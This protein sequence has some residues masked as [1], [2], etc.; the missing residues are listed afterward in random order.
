MPR[1][2]A[3]SNKLFP[4]Q[5]ARKRA[6]RKNFRNGEASVTRCSAFAFARSHKASVTR[7]SAS[8]LRGR[9]R[10]HPHELPLAI[11]FI[12]LRTGTDWLQRPHRRPPKNERLSAQ[13]TRRMPHHRSESF[14]LLRYNERKRRYPCT[15]S[16]KQMFFTRSRLAGRGVVS[17]ESISDL[18]RL[19]ES[20]FRDVTLLKF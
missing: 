19:A 18:A 3:C 10:T 13:K 15:P 16:H 6:K 20:I 2:N 9:I 17:A 7:C 14:F 12:V 1:C 4:N 5:K 11:A 8:P